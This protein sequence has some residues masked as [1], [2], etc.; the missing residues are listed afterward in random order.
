MF[1][2]SIPTS[3][4]ALTILSSEGNARVT[5][6]A[7]QSNARTFDYQVTVCRILVRIAFT[8]MTHSLVISVCLDHNP[9]AL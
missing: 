1:V 8:E 2:S 9:Q 5:I 4:E 3:R 6:F 7:S